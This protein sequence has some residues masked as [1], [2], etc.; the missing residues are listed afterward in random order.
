MTMTLPAA[1]ARFRR[2]IPA[3]E[4]AL[5][6][7]L[8]RTASLMSSMITARRDTGAAA[9]TGQAALMRLV[10][11]QQSIVAAQND[12]IRVHAEMVKVGEVVGVGDDGTCPPQTGVLAE[13]RG[14]ARAA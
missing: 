3:A 9:A 2:E 13:T 4:A 10:R 5:D 7:A 6:E 8:L 11:T 12:M 14:I 1:T